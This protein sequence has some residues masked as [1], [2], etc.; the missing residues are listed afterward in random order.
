MSRIRWRSSTDLLR[1]FNSAARTL[2]GQRTSLDGQIVLDAQQINTK[3]TEVADLNGRIRTASLD[4]GAGAAVSEPD[5]LAVVARARREPLRRDVQ[6]LEQVRLACAV[7]PGREHEPR[8]EREL[9]P[10][11]RPE[12]AERDRLDD[13]PGRRIG[14]TRYVKSSPS[15]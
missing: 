13:Q 3:A 12:A 6:R 14:M 5:Q 10:L 7:R 9:E 1:T 2:D 11:V 8:P 4:G 15:P